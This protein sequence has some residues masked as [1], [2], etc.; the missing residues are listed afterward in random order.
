MLLS[1]PLCRTVFRRLR[2]ASLPGAPPLATGKAPPT[3]ADGF[4]FEFCMP[5]WGQVC[6]ALHRHERAQGAQRH[7][8]AN[9][10]PT[11]ATSVVIPGFPSLG[12]DKCEF[13]QALE[14]VSVPF[15]NP[16]KKN[17]AEFPFRLRSRQAMLGN[18]PRGLLLAAFSLWLFGRSPGR[19]RWRRCRRCHRRC[20]RAR[21][22]SRAS[23]GP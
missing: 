13:F 6:F 4:V 5:F 23:S 20:S 16:W 22:R 9:T 1:P 12:K 19:R 15:S 14:K 7:S 11:S 3:K 2:G 18:P 8:S 10:L 21:G 17:G